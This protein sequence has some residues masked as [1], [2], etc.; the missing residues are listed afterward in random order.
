MGVKINERLKVLY[1]TRWYPNR[2]D[3]M[4]GLFIQR[5]AE[6]ANNCCDVGVVYAHQTDERL[7]EQQIYVIDYN[8][9]NQVP[10]AKIYYLSSKI[11]L[12]H[13]NKLVN[14]Y[15]FFRANMI[16]L[17]LMKKQL[18]G[19]DLVHIHILTRLGLLGLYYKLFKGIPYLISEHWSRYLDLTGSFNGV[20]RK[21]ITRVIVKHASSVTTVTN[22]LAKAMKSH[23]LLND[24]YVVLP[25]VVD[26]TFLN[27]PDNALL[28]NDPIVFIHVSCFEDKSKNISGLLRTISN[29]S[30]IRN[31]FIFKLVGDGMDKDW[32]RNLASELGLTEKQV[33]FTGLLEGEK[34]VNEMASADMLIVFSNYENLPVVINESLSLGVPVIAT[35][36]G[37]IPER[38]NNENGVL[39]EAGNEDQLLANLISFLDGDL[40]FNMDKIKSEA[41]IEFSPESIG[42]MLCELY[43]KASK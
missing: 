29:L 10:T 30:E 37:G 13:F 6:S 39:I 32:L 16:G 33:I 9:E 11:K 21:L 41:Q 25:N 3:P 31:D 20:F 17:K 22:N 26:N 4:P 15:R 2:W 42:T 19:F 34:L 36:V 12:F 1:L 23:K 28:K 35:K 18:G 7:C 24:N 27:K 14:I 38:I 8:E 43:T 5:H 40:S